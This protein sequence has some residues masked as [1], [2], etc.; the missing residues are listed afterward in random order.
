MLRKNPLWEVQGRPHVRKEEYLSK[1]FAEL[2]DRLL[3]PT[4]WQMACHETEIVNAGDYVT[5]DIGDESVIVAR[6]NDGEIKAHHNVCPHRGNKLAVGCGSAKEFRCSYHG[7]RFDLDGNNV[8]VQ[9]Q[10]DW[11]GSICNADLKLHEVKVES[12][13]GW[14]WIN[15]DRNAESL[16]D[17][18][19][20][21]ADR[22]KDYDFG[23]YKIRW[24]KT[25]ELACNWKLVVEAFNEG[26]HVAGTHPHILNY[27]EDY[28][29]GIVYGIHSAYWQSSAKAP[30]NPALIGRSRRRGGVSEG[31]DFRKFLVM[32]TEDFDEALRAMVTP[33]QIQAAHEVLAELPPTAPQADVIGLWMEKRKEIARQ[34][35]IKWFDV[36]NIEQVY[37]L[38]PNTVFLPTGDG[39]LWYRARPIKGNPDRCLYDVYSL[40]RAPEGETPPFTHDVY[41]DWRAADPGRILAEDYENVERVQR[42]MKSSAFRESRLNPVQE[43]CISNFH[44]GLRD[45]LKLE[46]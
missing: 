39:L 31:D 32:F 40:D 20:D 28:T 25:F 35:G 18:L 43:I 34:K 38:F 23:Q 26:Y 3:W 4:V 42:G 46:P 37:H 17:Y 16:Q 5:Y 6:G 29:Q 7:W 9:D 41:P 2:E 13:A 36:T 15:M 11:A 12:W 19:G 44:R 14:V 10:E 45:W 21:V 1:D 22:V 8:H 30:N 33:E 24:Y 27:L